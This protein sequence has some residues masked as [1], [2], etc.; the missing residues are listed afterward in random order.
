MRTFDERQRQFGDIVDV[1][2]AM[3]LLFGERRFRFAAVGALAAPAVALESQEPSLRILV[4]ELNAMQID[5]A[6]RVRHVYRIAL[7]RDNLGILRRKI[8]R[9]DR[10]VARERLV[11]E[12]VFIRRRLA[13]QH[14]VVVVELRLSERDRVASLDDR[15]LR[16]RRVEDR[17]L[18]ANIRRRIDRRGPRPVRDEFAAD[19]GQ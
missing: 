19:Y 12:D 4:D 8:R 15:A 17:V 11:N 16:P 9:S 6:A 3:N 2:I 7:L 18:D 13:V 1:N 10:R 5:R 14:V